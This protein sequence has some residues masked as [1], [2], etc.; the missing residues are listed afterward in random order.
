MRLT[1]YTQADLYNL[2]VSIMRN[3]S[4][5]DYPFAPR[6]FQRALAQ[7][8][9]LLGA[10][11]S[12]QTLNLVNATALENT[13]GTLLDRRGLESNT[14]R[15]GAAPSRGT[16]RMIPLVSPAAAAYT[17]PANTVVIV[18]ATATQ[19]EKAFKLE[20]AA[21]I[22]LAGTQS[23]LVSI[24]SLEHG[25]SG[26][27]IT[28]AT[29]LAL[30]YPIGGI[31]HFL[32]AT[33]TGGGVSRQSDAEYRSS[34]RSAKRAHGE[35]TWAGLESLLKTVRIASGNRVTVAKVFHDF[36]LGTVTA[37]IDDGS[38]DS[39]LVGPEDVTTYAFGGG[40]YWTYNATGSDV[41]VRLPYSHLPSWNDGVDAMLE[42]DTGAGFV[43]QVEGTDYWVDIDTGII[44]LATPLSVGDVLRAQFDFY[45]GLVGEAARQVN[46]VYGSNTVRGWRP[47][48][49]SIR[50]RGPVSVNNPT[51]A[52]TL[53]FSDDRDSHFGRELASALVLTY[54]NSLNIGDAASYS[55]I[56][57]ILLS[58]PG[59]DRLEGYTLD[60]GVVDVSPT[61]PYGVIRGDAGSITV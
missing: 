15:L 31:S 4:G 41:Y 45:A 3:V 55:K 21:T 19:S 32:L 54:L 48:G 44:A 11:A 47:V 8:A 25:I 18:P 10:S 28:A 16:G 56:N 59:A 14:P 38:G 52:A 27:D 12:A 22:P 30:K 43:T 46:G 61:S 2:A 42:I 58:V 20:A 37:Y 9:S 57:K 23:N 53:F 60:G 17:A 33:D 29:Q 36:V 40:T 35:S 49:Q 7:V 24:V 5:V 51:V 39:S 1:L 13:S 50:I 26:N 6:T 34:I